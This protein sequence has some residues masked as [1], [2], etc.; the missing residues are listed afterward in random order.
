MFL[1]LF[2]KCGIPCSAAD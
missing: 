1:A 2:P